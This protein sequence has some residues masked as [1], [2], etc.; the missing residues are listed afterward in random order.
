MS[1]QSVMID[2]SFK[3]VFGNEAYG[4]DYHR[5]KQRTESESYPKCAGLEP[6]HFK[7]DDWN[8]YADPL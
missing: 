1:P 2:S 7:V 3:P 5:Y 4:M 8:Q 6:N